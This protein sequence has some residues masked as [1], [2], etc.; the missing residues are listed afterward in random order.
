MKTEKQQLIFVYNA[1]SSLFSQVIDYAHKILS[2]GTYECNLCK[3]TYGNLGV[4][5][6][7]K[8]YLQSLKIPV[9][10]LHKDE[11]SKKYPKLT[12]TE[13]PAVF[14][15]NSTKETQLITAAELSS[16]KSIKELTVLVDSKLELVP[17]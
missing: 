17:T 1:D 12:S 11:F 7:W 16:V 3:L 4:K 14:L 9:I 5:K 15:A 13:L 2:P 6:E 8:S 10:F